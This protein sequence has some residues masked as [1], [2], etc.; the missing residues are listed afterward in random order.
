MQVEI[1]RSLEYVLHIPETS[2][3]P[4]YGNIAQPMWQWREVH[5]GNMALKELS[6]STLSS[7]FLML[8]KIRR[9]FHFEIPPNKTSTFH[10][11]I[12]MPDL[13]SIFHSLASHAPPASGSWNMTCRH[14]QKK[15]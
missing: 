13:W 3:M 8:A 9:V 12:I 4:L 15:H 14:T 7:T 2:S 6:L 10:L 11:S 5:V 1:T